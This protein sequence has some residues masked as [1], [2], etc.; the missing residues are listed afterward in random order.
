MKSVPRIAWLAIAACAA[1]N[2]EEVDLSGHFRASAVK[3]VEPQAA[4]A[5][6]AARLDSLHS[7][8]LRMPTPALERAV[9]CADGLTPVCY[10]LRDR[11]VVYRGARAFMPR[12]EGLTAD[13]VALR[14]DRVILRYTFR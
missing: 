6:F 10:D 1:A 8:S 14:H 3:A 13:G 12:L 7:F 5:P 9:P 4:A 2:A 11:G